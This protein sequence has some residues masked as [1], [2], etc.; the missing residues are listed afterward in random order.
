[1][2][3]VPAS[4]GEHRQKQEQQHDESVSAGPVVGCLKTHG[5]LK[6]LRVAW[7]KLACP[8]LSAEQTLSVRAAQRAELVV[9]APKPSVLPDFTRHPSSLSIQRTH[10]SFTHAALNSPH[11]RRP[12]RLADRKHFNPARLAS[13]GGGAIPAR[14]AVL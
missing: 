7:A 1:M 9:K 13:R 6:R 2:V 3:P 12:V 11:I 14:L 4:C 10:T 5:F 8:F